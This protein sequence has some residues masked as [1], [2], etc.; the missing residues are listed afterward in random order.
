MRRMTRETEEEERRRRR[1][2]GST[3]VGHRQR[4][5]GEQGP[6]AQGVRRRRRKGSTGVRRKAYTK[7]RVFVCA[8]TEK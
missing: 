7:P 1:R 4:M 6:Q 3:G 8:Y 2:R 5:G